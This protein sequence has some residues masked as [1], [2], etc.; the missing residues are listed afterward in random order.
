MTAQH[1]V[2]RPIEICHTQGTESS[3]TPK[4]AQRLD[5]DALRALC[6]IEDSGGVTRAAELLGLSQSAVSHK[7]KRLESSLECELL[8]RRPGAP[9]FTAAGQDLLAY[10]KR[11][12]GIHDEAL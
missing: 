2:D 4:P 5:I 1:N 10:A 9:L 6:A 7:V 3:M 11:I 8:R 12:L